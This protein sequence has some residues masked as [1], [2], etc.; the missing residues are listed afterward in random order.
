MQNI[1]VEV[2]INNKSQIIARGM[3]LFI[4]Y[5]VIKIENSKQKSSKLKFNTQGNASQAGITFSNTYEANTSEYSIQICP[6]RIM[7]C[8]NSNN[9][10]TITAI[11]L[12]SRCANTTG[13]DLTVVL[14]NKIDMI[15]GKP[16][17]I[18]YTIKGSK[19]G[20][21]NNFNQVIYNIPTSTGLEVSY[22]NFERLAFEPIGETGLIYML[23]DKIYR[24]VSLIKASYK[25]TNIIPTSVPGW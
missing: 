22:L 20:S 17:E 14:K 16:K 6:C 21:I 18:K 24:N 5:R 19:S 11:Q 25:F 8:I 4:A 1:E 9:T 3:D 7:E 12:F 13:F 10:N 15:T 2:D 23:H